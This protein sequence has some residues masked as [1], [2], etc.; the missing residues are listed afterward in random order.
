MR[1]LT[2]L[3][4]TVGL[5]FFTTLLAAQT[6]N[7][8]FLP[9]DYRSTTFLSGRVGVG[10]QFSNQ[11]SNLYFFTETDVCAS[12]LVNYYAGDGKPDD[13][14]QQLR[15]NRYRGNIHL[16]LQT[17]KDFKLYGTRFAKKNEDIEFKNRSWTYLTAVGVSLEAGLYRPGRIAD[18]ETGRLNSR[19]DRKGKFRVRYDVVSRYHSYYY[20]PLSNTVGYVTLNYSKLDDRWGININWGNDLFILGALKN[21]VVNHDHG[22]TNSAF[23]NGYWRPNEQRGDDPNTAYDYQPSSLQKLE[24]GPSLRMITDRRTMKRI[25]TNQARSGTYDVLHLAN[26]FHGYYGMRFRVEGGVYALGGLI[27]KDDM[28]WGREMQRFAHQGYSHLPNSS[29]GRIFLKATGGVNSPLFPW[30]SEPFYHKKPRFYYELTPEGNYQ[31]F[32]AKN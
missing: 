16:R 24:L 14:H 27:G 21:F 18:L 4:A 5:V 19:F 8:G 29:V 28:F 7:R 17:T 12:C 32:G 31:Y 3:A 13:L 10:Y 1:T 25:T 22:E 30:E 9:W 2:P 11:N 15:R 26:S 6:S 23:I 20:R